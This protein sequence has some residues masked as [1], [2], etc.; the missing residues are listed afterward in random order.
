MDRGLDR[1]GLREQ[2]ACRWNVGGEKR[3]VHCT[4]L[5]LGC[6]FGNFHSRK[7]GWGELPPTVSRVNL[8]QALDQCGPEAGEG[9]NFATGAWSCFIW[10]DFLWGVVS[11]RPWLAPVLFIDWPRGGPAVP[12]P[13]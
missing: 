7:L 13:G 10:E 5:S 8:K 12:S 9:G 6:W 3:N 2:V 4:V 1:G 11:C